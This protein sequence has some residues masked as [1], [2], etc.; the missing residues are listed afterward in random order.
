[1]VEEENTVMNASPCSDS[2]ESV[3]I[4]QSEL[5]TTLPSLSLTWISVGDYV[6]IMS[7]EVNSVICGEPYLALQALVQHEV[8]EVHLYKS[9]R[10]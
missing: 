7:G 5:E 6:A 10:V 9:L 4:K 8:G 1:M 2:N 3:G